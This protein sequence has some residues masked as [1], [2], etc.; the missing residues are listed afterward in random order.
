MRTTHRG[1]TLL[2]VMVALLLFSLGLI[3]L[4]GLLTVSVKTNQ[5][6]YLRTQATFLAQAMADRMHANPLGLWGTS[7]NLNSIAAPG[8]VLGTTSAPT[9][10][11][12]MGSPIT[13][14]PAQLAGRDLTMFQYQLNTF[15]PNASVAVACATPASTPSASQ[16]L[17]LPPYS[18]T[19]EIF[20]QWSQLPITGQNVATVSPETFDWV[21]QP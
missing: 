15:L 7:Y 9:V 2:E 11:T 14:S 3:G 17:L 8:S 10:C 12:S 1:F 21:F 16:L 6:A 5:S 13:C 18:T 4:A 19:C 20:I